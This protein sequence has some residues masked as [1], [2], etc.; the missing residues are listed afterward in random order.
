MGHY[1]SGRAVNW[2]GEDV[3]FRRVR[4]TT[5]NTSDPA[6]TSDP[7]GTIGTASRDGTGSFVLTLSDDWSNVT[8]VSWNARSTTQYTC[9][10]DAFTATAGAQSIALTQF[11]AGSAADSNNV[12]IDMVI[13]C[14]RN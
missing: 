8:L 4:L 9:Q 3:E 14:M 10:L 5:A 1:S 2:A 13:A 11:T 7:A 12:V 6:I